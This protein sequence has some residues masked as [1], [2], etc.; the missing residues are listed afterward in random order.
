MRAPVKG[1]DLRLTASDGMPIPEDPLLAAVANRKAT[2]F[3]GS[4]VLSDSDDDDLEAKGAGGLLGAQSAASSPSKKSPLKVPSLQTSLDAPRWK[5]ALHSLDYRTP[6]HDLYAIPI[7]QTSSSPL[8]ADKEWSVSL[9]VSKI[10]DISHLVA[11]EVN[12]LNEN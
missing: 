5:T 7:Q 8:R 6:R 4:H 12:V 1:S 2:L 3:K 10:A 9:D 11:R